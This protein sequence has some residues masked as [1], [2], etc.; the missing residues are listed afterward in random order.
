MKDKI[1]AS[2]LAAIIALA[3]IVSAAVTLGDY[4]TFLFKNHNLDAY[5]VVG[6]G[7]APADVVGAVD[8]AVRLAGES[9]ELV[10]VS[11]DT[12]LSGATSEEIELGDTIAGGNYLDTA[13]KQYKLSGLKDS[14]VSF[15]D[16]TYD[17]HEE[18]QL[19]STANNLDVETSLTSSDDK[20]ADGVYLE[21]QKDALTYA[22]VFDESINVSKA[23]TTDP[24]E[25]EFLGKTLVIE[26]V[27]DSDT[28]TA[29]V[30]DEYTLSVGD[31]VK[32]LGKTVTLKNVFSSGSVLVDVDGVSATVS[33][34]QVKTVNG[35]KVK[36]TDYGYS[37]TKEDR[38]AVLLLG[39]ET[40]KTYNNGDAY[41][42]QDKNNP[43]WVWKLSG[44]TS[45]SP[46]IAIENDFIRDDYTDNPVT[47]GQCYEFPNAYAKVCL[48]SLTVNS[49]Q[50]YEVSV[51][52]GVDLTDAGSNW[53]SSNTVL[54]IRS[55]GLDEGLVELVSGNSY[56]T[57]TLYLKLDSTNGR[58]TVFYVD[59][60]NDV[61]YAGNITL[62]GTAFDVANV[63]YQDT[64]AGDLKFT[65]QN[66]TGLTTFALTLDSAVSSDDVVSVWTASGGNFD[67]LGATADDSESTEL[68]WNGNNIGTK[69]YDLRT[70]YGVVI[71]NPDSNGAADK[72]VVHVPADQVKAKVVV[73]GPS[74]SATTTEGGNIKKVVPVTTT[75]AKLDTEVDPATVGKHLVLVGGPAVN[76]LTAQAMGLSY[77]TYGSSGLLPFAEGEGYIKVYDG[78]FK[79][80]Q[81]VVVVAGWE[82]ANTRM[83]TSL[84]QQFDTFAGQLGS[85]TAVKV[86]SLSA[87]GI[88]PA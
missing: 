72:V 30:G 48:D 28:F 64:R 82:E 34:G 26:S 55:A 15:Q 59:N 75:V 60:D 61:T 35:I 67:H 24:L 29:R 49:Y 33:Q 57:D 58:V 50:Q 22:F 65:I 80:G 1:I 37:D 5:V 79:S 17:F 87:S 86:T 53:G 2:V 73:Y 42:G 44:L 81:V 31:S 47:V 62:A 8:L 68:T 43:L 13:L 4:P 25:I 3:P 70:R 40:T 16:D 56:K 83:A 88:T 7:A 78:V 51:E 84:L 52:T 18:I 20:Y 41:I 39:E 36:P 76:R 6:S 74:G 63:N 19:T 85:N 38:V 77:P 46:T 21:I 27:A 71:K 10:S 32:V 9:Y 23:T 54:R 12:V 45:N 14:S 11:G 66:T 69:E